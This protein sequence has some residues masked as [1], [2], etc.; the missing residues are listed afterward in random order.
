MSSRG[1][2]QK[3]AVL[4][5]AAIINS[6]LDRM[7]M[8]RPIWLVIGQLSFAFFF[9]LY[10]LFLIGY[11]APG[12]VRSGILTATTKGL[13]GFTGV[14]SFVAA[15]FAGLSIGTLSSGSLTDRLGRRRVFLAALLWF[16]V[17]EAVMAFQQTALGLNAMHFLVGLGL[18]VE[19]VTIDT[20]ISEIVPKEVR[21][22][23]FAFNQTLGFAAVP[24]VA[25][26]AWFFVPRVFLGLAGWRW[27]VLV[28]ALGALTAFVMGL[29]LPESARW[30]AAR[31][32]LPE[33]DRVVGALERRVAQTV[34]E[35]PSLPTPAPA[36]LMSGPKGRFADIW[37]PPYRSRTIMLIIFNI[38]QTVG[39]YGFVNW[40]PTM[41][42][43]RGMTI[44]DSLMYLSV[45]ALAAPV[46]PLLGLI[47]AD[48]FER[49]HMIMLSA[50]L[51][52]A[53]GLVFGGTGSAAVVIVTGVGITL[54][55][56]ILSFSYHAYQ[57]EIFPT[58]IRAK[59]VS[60]VYAWSRISAMISA[61]IIAHVLR[62]AGAIGVFILI[63]AAMFV[64]VVV[65]GSFGPRSLNLS[66]EGDFAE[67]WA[68][69]APTRR[70]SNG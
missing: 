29:S 1:Y 18:G 38:F 37:R 4:N 19:M 53:L 39:F 70:S 26:L 51:V 45:I 64:V 35:L 31:G 14:A 22:R 12:V 59:A 11:I 50:A 46:G 48:R 21:G 16:A 9:E 7:P 5:S 20:Y 32:R 36:P 28:G 10:D 57:A 42:V 34:G 55:Q 49:K 60:F 68:D 2:A 62:L 63:A 24:V 52:A 43:S 65:I 58:P 47:F 8:C 66:V 44:V 23:A 61:F 33:A 30:L 27:V 41:L 15:L 40:A 13:F 54:C 6:R 67:P 69:S 56:N 3:T 17:C 25:V